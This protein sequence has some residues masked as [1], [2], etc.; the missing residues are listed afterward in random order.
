[1]HGRTSGGVCSVYLISTSARRAH[2]LSSVIC[3]TPPSARHSHPLLGHLLHYRRQLRLQGLHRGGGAGR[4]LLRLRQDLQLL[5]GSGL[6]D[7]GPGGLVPVAAGGEGRSR[8][9]LHGWE[10]RGGV[11]RGRKGRRRSLIQGR[12]SADRRL[13]SRLLPL[14][15]D[16]EFLVTLTSCIGGRQA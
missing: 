3:I 13:T 15:Q 16:T 1:M 4:R 11:R 14:S 2:T 7:S 5:L 8:H 6:E 12:R 9:H 10:A